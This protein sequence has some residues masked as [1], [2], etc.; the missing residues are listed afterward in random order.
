MSEAEGRPRP[1]YAVC[2]RGLSPLYPHVKPRRSGPCTQHARL[3]LRSWPFT[4]AE[5]SAG[6]RPQTCM[7]V[8]A[9]SSDIYVHACPWP[10]AGLGLGK[11]DRPRPAASTNVLCTDH[12]AS[13]SH[14]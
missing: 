3:G 10:R 11:R 1:V 6:P 2:K 7:Y 9:H 13:V 5:A 4:P 12:P 14:E 8:N